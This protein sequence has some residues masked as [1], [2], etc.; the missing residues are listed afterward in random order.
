METL[1]IVYHDPELIR[2]EKKE[3]GDWIDLRLAEDVNMSAGEYKLLSLGIGMI[4]PDGYEAHV[5]PRSSTCGRYGIMLANSQ[6]II[7]NSYSG[8][9][10]EWKFPA[11]ACRDTFIPKNTRICQFRIVE[12]QPELLFETV[13]HLNS[14][15]RGGLGST[16]L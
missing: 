7:D 1:K 3:K 9:A 13:D 12:K 4:V 16:G 11:Y 5:V 6:G 8:D 10:D 14:T 2:I 15:S